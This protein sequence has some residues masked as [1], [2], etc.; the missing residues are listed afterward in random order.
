[1][2]TLN[3][4][5]CGCAE[6]YRTNYDKS[7]EYLYPPELIELYTNR[8]ASTKRVSHIIV[9][10]HVL[11]LYRLLERSAVESKKFIKQ[12]GVFLLIIYVMPDATYHSDVNDDTMVMKSVEDE[13][14]VFKA[15]AGSTAAAYHHRTMNI[16]RNNA[17]VLPRRGNI[18]LKNTSHK[19]NALQAID[20]YRVFKEYLDMLTPAPT[21]FNNLRKNET[22]T[23][24]DFSRN[25]LTKNKILP[26]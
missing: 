2:A 22:T 20:F 26:K 4:L 23:F 9:V 5:W 21:I 6:I 10:S 11:D 25:L 13:H 1:M 24:H 19:I 18:Y 14:S 8:Q 7:I 16:L 15:S 3:E 17:A 12:H